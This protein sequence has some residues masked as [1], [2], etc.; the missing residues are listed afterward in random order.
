MARPLRLS[1][2][3]GV[4]HVT[5][6]GNERKAL[7]RDD[8]DRTRFVAAGFLPVGDEAHAQALSDYSAAPPFTTF[9]MNGGA[10]V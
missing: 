7:V 5:A 10:A 6:R 9:S 3:A 8:G 4:S 2:A 1:F